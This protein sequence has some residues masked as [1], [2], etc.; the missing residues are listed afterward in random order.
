MTQSAHLPPLGLGKVQST[1]PNI[2]NTRK[3]ILLYVHTW[4]KKTHGATPKN[5]HLSLMM[6]KIHERSN[7]VLKKQEYQELIKSTT[8]ILVKD[9]SKVK[10]VKK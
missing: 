2:D 3:S 4:D 1:W 9:S 8:G 5:H 10:L 6:H 7:R